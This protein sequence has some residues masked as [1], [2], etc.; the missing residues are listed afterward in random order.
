MLFKG[1]DD[2]GGWIYIPVHSKIT[3]RKWKLLF[4]FSKVFPRAHSCFVWWGGAKT[5]KSDTER[6]GSH[7]YD[8][9]TVGFS[10]SSF[11][12]IIISSLYYL[13][14]RLFHQLLALL[15]LLL[16]G[17]NTCRNIFV[18]YQVL[19]FFFFLAISIHKTHQMFFT[20]HVPSLIYASKYH[21]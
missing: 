9:I 18:L 2:G 6:E 19:F 3:H 20:A 14:M 5:L 16:F 7:S 13:R 11:F 17:P 21:S 4:E 8:Y 15:L 1:S 10:L 12:F